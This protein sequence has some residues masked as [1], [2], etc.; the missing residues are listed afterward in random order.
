MPVNQAVT[1]LIC[2]LT[3]YTVI[4]YKICILCFVFQNTVP[5]NTVQV[6]T[7][8]PIPI[9]A[10]T[11]ST[12][13]SSHSIRS[14]SS[15]WKTHFFAEI[16]RQAAK[17]AISQPLL[18]GIVLGIALFGIACASIF[19]MIAEQ[20]LA[21]RAIAFNRLLI[22][23]IA[24]GGWHG[25]QQFISQRSVSSR[26]AALPNQSVEQPITWQ[27]LAL[28]LVAGVSFAASFTCAAWSLTQ[29]S[30]AN[31]ALLNNMMPIFTT[32][33]AWLLLGKQFRLRFVLGLGVA[34][35][36]VVAIG[37]QDLHVSRSQITGDGAALAAAVLLAT[38]LL[39]VEQLRSKFTTPVI[40]LVIS[41]VGTVAIAPALLLSGD[42]LFPARWTTGCAV[43]ALALISQVMGH[44]LLTYSLKQFSS[45]LV[46][47]S[48]L[49]IPVLSAILAMLLFA[50]QIS[51]FNGFAF[52][53]VLA[54][55]YLSISAPQQS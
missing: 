8:T 37:I 23:T 36:G 53:L 14:A 9:T 31:S 17:L 22:A 19:V 35:T 51:L 26:E 21:P 55:I 47:V 40:M 32:L 50:Q 18:G 44:G 1:L 10:M 54:G 16:S 28:F 25:L 4:V 20:E 27:D 43:S 29:T 30:V 13:F 41:F 5:R 3:L 11:V 15:S 24:F 33:G 42:V 7:L 52:L 34:I 46:S 6:L 45:E 49:A 2:I 48:M 39:S 12:A 38:A